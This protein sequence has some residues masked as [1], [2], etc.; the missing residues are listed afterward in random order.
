MVSIAVAV[1]G[2][3]VTCATDTDVTVRLGRTRVTDQ[4]H[5]SSASFTVRSERWPAHILKGADVRIDADGMRRFTGTVSDLAVEHVT[6][7]E[8]GRWVAEF[9]ILA[10][11]A[12]ASWGRDIIGDEPWPVEPAAARAQRIAGLV[13]QPLLVQGGEAL[14][15]IGRDVDAQPA[16]DVLDDLAQGCGAWLFDTP[17]GRTVLQAIDSRRDIGTLER[18]ADQTATWAGFGDGT[19]DQ[20]DEPPAEPDLPLRLDPCWVVWEPRW[21]TSAE[22]VNHADVGYGAI[23]DG[24]AEQPVATSTDQPSIDRWGRHRIRIPTPLADLAA[25]LDRGRLILERAAQ[26]AWSLGQVQVDTASMPAPA[27][28]S[29]LQSLPGRLVTVTGLPQPAPSAQFDG[30]LEGWTETWRS[31]WDGRVRRSITLA[32]SDIRHSFAVLTWRT[33]APADLPWSAVDAGWGDLISND[34]LE[35]A[36]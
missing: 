25:A 29:L 23:P 19:W 27:L 34:D 5:P 20:Q 22:L 15:V 1:G 24:D 9:R 11:G 32:L 33:I 4:G 2:V 28:N 14:S 6:D 13:G 12:L 18:W 30:V 10:A 8:T 36:A 31:G 26:P 16:I 3:D 17:D 21:E 7:P 35:A